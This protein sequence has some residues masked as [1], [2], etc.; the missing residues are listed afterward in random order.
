MLNLPLMRTIE[1]HYSTVL[2]TEREATFAGLPCEVYEHLAKMKLSSTFRSLMQGDEAHL[3][4]AYMASKDAK[5][6]DQDHVLLIITLPDHCFS[7]AIVHPAACLGLDNR[8]DKTHILWMDSL[9]SD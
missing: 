7:A 2:E 8:I 5:I 9:G 6:F 4:A 1:E 3:E